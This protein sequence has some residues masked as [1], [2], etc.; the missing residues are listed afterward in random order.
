M[1]HTHTRMCKTDSHP[2]APTVQQPQAVP[3]IVHNALPIQGPWPRRPH[4]WGP[5]V[6]YA[7]Q[8]IIAEGVYPS[9]VVLWAP[10]AQPPASTPAH[11]VS[12]ALLAPMSRSQE[13]Q[14]ASTAQWGPTHR[15]Q[16]RRS[17]LT[18]LQ[19]PFSQALVFQPVLPVQL[20]N[21]SLPRPSTAPFAAQAHGR[22][23]L[24]AACASSVP[25][26]PTP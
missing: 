10:I 16:P 4:A 5:S 11:S 23:W 3:I 24:E 20:A 19:G 7:P 1:H 21:I 17:A 25:Q 13:P 14:R 8:A 26:A 18:V 15:A 22:V 9:R 6:K 2:Q 12:N